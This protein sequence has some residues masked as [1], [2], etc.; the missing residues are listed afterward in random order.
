M[1]KNLPKF[2]EKLH[3]P[4]VEEDPSLALC[5]WLI[6]RSIWTLQSIIM[7]KCGLFNVLF[8]FI[9]KSKFFAKIEFLRLEAR[10]SF[11]LKHFRKTGLVKPNWRIFFN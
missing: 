11:T 9:F 10:F 7:N 5:V 3:F 1:K 4:S 8:Q 6:V 2:S